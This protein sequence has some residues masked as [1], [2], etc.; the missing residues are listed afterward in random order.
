MA[1][2]ACQPQQQKVADARPT[3]QPPAASS[4]PLDPFVVSIDAQR[5]SILIDKAIEGVREAPA[6]NGELYDQ[7]LFR[8][9]AALKSGAA[10]LL[11]LRNDICGKGLLT[12]DA[13]TLPDF[14]QWTREPPS[15]SVTVEEIDQRS[16]WLSSAQEKFVELGCEAGKKAT[17]DELFCSV[18]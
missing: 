13:C 12:G 4:E 2:A 16:Q 7:Q 8:A 1:L 6:A 18:E 14:P 5:W 17:K 10:H 15:P 11:E 3:A 9:D